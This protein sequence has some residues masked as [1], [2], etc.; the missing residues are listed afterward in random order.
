MTPFNSITT[1]VS[2]LGSR[3]RRLAR[4]AVNLRH[5]NFAKLSQAPFRRKASVLIIVIV[6]LLLLAILGAAYISTTRSARVASAQNVMSG[7]VDSTLN[8]IAKICEGTIV[9]DLNDTSG[10]L[11]GNTDFSGNSNNNRSCYQG[12]EGTAPAT[13]SPAPIAA[14]YNAAYLAGYQ[15]Y[16]YNPGDIVND[17][18][19]P[20]LFYTLPQGTT[21]QGGVALSTANGWLPLNGHLP[22]TA[23]ASDP[24]V[25]DRVPDPANTGTP[26]WTALSQSVNLVGANLAAQSIAGTDFIDPVT[27]NDLTKAWLTTAPFAPPSP[28]VGAPG[29]T[30]PL[31]PTAERLQNGT[32]VPA[33]Q[34][35][36]GT[37][38][39]AGDADGDSIADSLLF[40]IPGANMQGLTWY[41]AVRII[42]NNSAINANTAWSRDA[43]VMAGGGTDAWNLTQA[44]VGLEELINNTSGTTKDSINTVNNYRF[45]QSAPSAAAYDEAAVNGNTPPT[46][47]QRTDFTFVSQGDAF[48][49]QLIRRI[50]NPGYIASGVRYLTLPISD[51]AALAYHF[52]LTNPSEGSPQSVLESL[53]PNSLWNGVAN[54][55]YN[56]TGSGSPDDSTGVTAWYN[57]N[58]KYNSGNSQVPIRALL[59]TRN[60]VS[61]YILPLFNNNTG[62]TSNT[63]Y[64]LA[65]TPPATSTTQPATSDPILPNYMLPYSGANNPHF[66][67]TW[68]NAAN[69]GLN[70]IVEFPGPNPST[71]AGVAAP[72]A[73]P[74]YTFIAVTGSGPGISTAQPPAALNTKNVLTAINNQYWQL[75]PWS[76]NPVK[77]NVNTATFRELFRAFWC[78]MA[79]NPSSSTPFGETPPDYQ[80]AGIYDNSPYNPQHQFRSPLRDPTTTQP[81]L[82]SQLDGSA[83][84]QPSG[85]ATNT[86]T[87]L[88]R[89]AIAAVNTLGLRDN[90]QTVISKTIILN[91]AFI[92]PTINAA[93][94]NQPVE[95]RVY[96]N[97]PQPYISEIYAD[98]FN[99]T[100]PNSAINPAG[101]I[102][103]ELFNPYPFAFALN[104]WQVAYINRSPNSAGG[105]TYPNLTLNLLAGLSTDAYGNTISIPAR[106][107]A[108]LENYYGGN[109]ALATTQPTDAQYRSPNSGLPETGSLTG[110]TTQ[111]TTQPS[112]T[113]TD[114]YVPNLSVVIGGN[115][116]ATTQPATTQPTGELVL[117]RP[118][119]YNGTYSSYTDKAQDPN[120]TEAPGSESYNEGTFAA[121]NLYDLIPVDS[122][123]FTGFPSAPDPT[124][125]P[126][127][128]WS[129]MRAKG[130]NNLFKATYPGQYNAGVTLSTPNN[131]RQFQTDT[132]QMNITQASTG[133][134]TWT[135][136][137]ATPEFGQ[138]AGSSYPYY[139][140][141]TPVAPGTTGMPTQV[142]NL[143]LGNGTDWM[144]FPNS[145]ASPQNPTGVAGTYAHPFGGFARN[146]DILDVPFIGAYRIRLLAAGATN[147]GYNPANYG[148][149]LVDAGNPGAFVELNSLP[150]DCQCA[151]IDDSFLNGAVVA[152]PLVVPS[153]NIG[154]FVPMASSANYVNAIQAGT[155]LN[156]TSSSSSFPLPDYYAWTRNIFN[157]LTAQSDTDAYTPN[158]D[159]NV[160]STPNG[161]TPAYTLFSY[162]PQNQATP[163]PPTPNLTADPTASDQIRQDNV[164]IDGLININTASWKVLSM[165]PL[166]P[167]NVANTEALAK[168]IVSYRLTHGPFTSIFD[169][170]FVPGFQT[171]EGTISATPGSCNASSATGLLSPADPGFGTAAPSSANPLAGLEDYQSDCLELTRISN[172][173]TTRSDTFTIY[174]EVQGWQN[175]GTT[176]ATPVTTRRYAFIVDRSAINADPTSRYLKT[177]VVPNN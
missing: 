160:S 128:A 54:S 69:Y 152:T 21:A 37:A 84:T 89:A 172:L 50:A 125:G 113:E 4:S 126:W 8:G 158:F 68:S 129:Y 80:L 64:S 52:C 100:G 16:T 86:N 94:V 123:D 77:A 34:Y 127:T 148:Y 23:I 171:A 93:P 92:A 114:I 79:G 43:L 105:A 163:I 56:P 51:E 28:L 71:G 57:N 122:Y 63:S 115:A 161:S 41:A 24:W 67:G 19:N 48:N 168:A 90:T 12:E 1:P 22:F 134:I 159:P 169:L 42:D 119:Q 108:L 7:D 47:S 91:N 104:G 176:L 116:S 29:S 40:A 131:P 20:F 61:N 132:E 30:T 81:S 36:T 87:M 10:N 38:F 118:R 26:I 111:P 153:Q 11:H 55:P 60:P 6:L 88:L 175:A 139:E 112:S 120:G 49:S 149:S 121:P 58:F 83:S 15:Q 44:S 151:A 102:A 138:S 31:T 154:R 167:G 99:G 145:V 107:Y 73:G 110:T 174:V 155:F 117:L 133:G 173:I 75:Q 70:D 25:A 96:S 141:K 103:V 146:G 150:M 46:G 9:D 27:G 136:T 124:T 162:P 17:A 85:T 143:A 106:G 76:V 164:G 170:N 33:L 53:L 140:Q 32:Y 130:A 13:E 177:L 72:Y 95:V 2:W 156:G 14:P 35:G 157:Y 78:A 82:A 18:L 135:D 98:N 39:T 137:Y 101:Y 66:K 59:V 97:A 74:N 109:T 147:N 165:L 144:H 45:H 166:V 65:P 142:Y 62:A 3:T 5:S